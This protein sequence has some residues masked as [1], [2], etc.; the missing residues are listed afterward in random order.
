[1]KNENNKFTNKELDLFIKCLFRP[2]LSQIF[3]AVKASLVTI[4]IIVVKISFL[5]FKTSH[6]KVLQNMFSEVN[7][8][9]ETKD[10]NRSIIG[11]GRGLRPFLQLTELSQEIGVLHASV[12]FNMEY[13]KDSE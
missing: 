6:W 13:L 3:A 9:P 10:K 1:M 5:R 8:K 2:I 7:V 11:V 4:Y 12:S